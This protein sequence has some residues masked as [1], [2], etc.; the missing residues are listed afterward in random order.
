MPVVEAPRRVTK[1]DVRTDG[2]VQEGR[3][4]RGLQLDRVAVKARRRRGHE[5]SDDRPAF[6]STST[7]FPWASVWSP[8]ASRFWSR[9]ERKIEA[10][11]YRFG[12]LG[13]AV[14]QS[15]R[16]LHEQPD[17]YAAA[18]CIKVRPCYDLPR[19]RTAA[20]DVSNPLESRRLGRE[21]GKLSVAGRVTSFSSSRS[22]LRSSW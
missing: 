18:T 10:R 6:S 7:P 4:D 11:S 22:S 12:G 20:K 13:P 3:R 9:P 19:Y 17:L 2:S 5:K 1:G 16:H 15:R 21:G 14:R 8:A